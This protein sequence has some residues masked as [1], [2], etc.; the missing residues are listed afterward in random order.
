MIV[1]AVNKAVILVGSIYNSA[2]EIC[3]SVY[4]LMSQVHV[5]SFP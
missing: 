2:K 3:F 1:M 4:F 5:Y